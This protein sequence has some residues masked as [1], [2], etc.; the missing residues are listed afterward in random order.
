MRAALRNP[1]C[2][3][4]PVTKIDRKLINGGEVGTVVPQLLAAY[5]AFVA[6]ECPA[7]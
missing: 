4:V 2:E 1:R 5:K 6:K 7:R 3:I